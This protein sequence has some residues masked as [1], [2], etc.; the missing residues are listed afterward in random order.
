VRAGIPRTRARVRMSVAAETRGVRRVGAFP[1]LTLVRG[2]RVGRNATVPTRNGGRNFDSVSVTRELGSLP[3]EKTR[4][5]PPRRPPPPPRPPTP[6]PPPP[7][8]PPSPV[9]PTGRD[10]RHAAGALPPR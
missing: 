10:A 5:P 3:R 6:P 9:T 1:G 2:E 8:P 7:P 4:P